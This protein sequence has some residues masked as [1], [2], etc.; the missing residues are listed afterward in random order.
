MQTIT[1][2]E[3]SASCVMTPESIAAYV[4]YETDNGAS[5]NVIRRCKRFTASLFDWLPEDKRI[6]KEQLLSWRQNLKDHGYTAQTEQNYAKG[7][8]RYLDYIGASQLRFNRG[9]PK[10]IAGQQ[11]GYL[12]AIEPTGEK[13]RKNLIWRCKCKCGK[14]VEYPATRLLTGNTLSC[15][16]LRGEHLQKVN[17]Y[18]DGTSLR[19]SIG[20]QVHSTL[21]QSGYTGVTRKHDKWR[22]YIRYKGKAFHL[23]YYAKLEDAVKARARGKE[24][25]Q[26][27]ASG[28]L[29]LYEELHKDDPERPSRDPIKNM[30]KEAENRDPEPSAARAIRSN[31]T[32]GY[33]GV[34]KK[35]D[36]WFARITYQKVTYQLGAYKDISQAI[37]I[38]KEAEQVLKT[39][40]DGF[41]EWVL[42]QQKMRE[43]ERLTIDF[44][45]DKAIINLTL[46]QHKIFLHI[47]KENYTAAMEHEYT[48]DATEYLKQYCATYGSFRAIYYALDGLVEAQ[49]IESYERNKYCG[50]IKIIFTD[51]AKHYLYRIAHYYTTDDIET[52]LLF[53][54]KHSIKLYSY[55]YANRD[56]LE[57]HNLTISVEELKDI[58]TSGE[59]V[60]GSFHQAIVKTAVNEINRVNTGATIG[61]EIIRSDRVLAYFTFSASAKTSDYRGDNT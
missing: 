19:Q 28:L 18:I 41:Q 12:T 26:M 59:Y 9:K 49:L 20:E 25:V 36:K 17:K 34:Y 21:A 37:A 58:L 46:L 8:N 6:T 14:E 22:A 2:I 5:E 4:Q 16:C 51:T 47:A 32:S 31:N 40:P 33:P 39:N 30:Q 52:M 55:L 60:T 53:R 57:S 45:K 7:I 13:N 29:D 11:F 1:Q 54:S 38:R 44:T 61:Y 23:G 48:F 15:G 43:Q 42:L 10:D 35:C 50:K 3:T 24:L 56:A 27:D